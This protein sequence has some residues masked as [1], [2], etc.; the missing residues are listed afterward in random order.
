M[1]ATIQ[2]KIITALW[3]NINVFDVHVRL[4][5][6]IQK[7]KKEKRNE[8]SMYEMPYMSF[9]IVVFLQKCKKENAV[10]K[11][12]FSSKTQFIVMFSKIMQ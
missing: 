3:L 7:L 12:E 11:S 8:A 9:Q 1:S 6:L 2:S 5:T 10:P 4:V